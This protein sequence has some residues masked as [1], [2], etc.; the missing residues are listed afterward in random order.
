M[1]SKFERICATIAHI[2]IIIW[3]GLIPLVAVFAAGSVLNHYR[4]TPAVTTTD[5]SGC[6]I[7][8]I[9]LCSPSGD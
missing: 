8:N 9:D 3:L 4:D 7:D 5:T 1:H 2:L 6:S